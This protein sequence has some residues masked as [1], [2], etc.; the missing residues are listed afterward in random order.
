MDCYEKR[1]RIVLLFYQAIFSIAEYE[2]LY[3]KKCLSNILTLLPFLS[4]GPHS[5]T[6]GLIQSPIT[7]NRNLPHFVFIFYLQ[8]Q[9][10][11][12]CIAHYISPHNLP[13]PHIP[14]THMLSIRFYH[15]TSTVSLSSVYRYPLSLLAI[16]L[17][18]HHFLNP[19]PSFPCLYPVS[20]VF[21]KSSGAD[22]NV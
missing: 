20:R 8:P 14:I 3:I 6:P 10:S 9:P 22:L 12:S 11:V 2:D 21:V 4:L 13:Q 19:H 15:F 1:I 16:F 5:L 18:H 7:T 17:F